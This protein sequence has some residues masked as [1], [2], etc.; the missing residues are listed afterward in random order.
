MKLHP[1]KTSLKAEENQ[2]KIEN[3]SGRAKQYYEANG[4]DAPRPIVMDDKGDLH[5]LNRAQR[6]KQ[7]KRKKSQSTSR[8]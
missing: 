3:W 7:L 8:K 5:W 4:K 1:T 6:R 2:Q